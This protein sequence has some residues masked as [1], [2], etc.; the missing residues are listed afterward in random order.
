[1]VPGHANVFPRRADRAVAAAGGDWERAARAS[2][3]RRLTFPGQ[4]GE[5][6][7]VLGLSRGLD[8]DPVGFALRDRRG[9][10]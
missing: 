5:A 9:R 10:L 2:E 4:M 7:K 8:L 6:F 1:M 3:V